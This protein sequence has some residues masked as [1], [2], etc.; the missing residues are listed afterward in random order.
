MNLLTTATLDALRVTG[1]PSAEADRA[2][3]EDA[4]ALRGDIRAE[5][6]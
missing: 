6:A 2:S 4:R 1:V 3:E 5:R